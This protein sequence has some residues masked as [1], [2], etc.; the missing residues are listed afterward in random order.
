VRATHEIASEEKPLRSRPIGLYL[1]ESTNIRMSAT[2]EEKC[3]ASPSTT[4]VGVRFVLL[5][6]LSSRLTLRLYALL[7]FS[8][9][10]IIRLVG[11]YRNITTQWVTFIG[12]AALGI[13]NASDE[14]LNLLGRRLRH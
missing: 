6:P 5:C 11:A 2:I 13:A 3:K 7:L 14:I 9:L 12:L 8:S 10:L 4:Q 1:E